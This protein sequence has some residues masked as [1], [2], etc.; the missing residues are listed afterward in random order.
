[1]LSATTLVV[2]GI[3]KNVFVPTLQLE[4]A[5][6][7]CICRK[8]SS[9]GLAILEKN[10]SYGQIGAVRF[11]WKTFPLFEIYSNYCSPSSENNSSFLASGP[12]CVTDILVK[13][14]Q[15]NNSPIQL[16]CNFNRV[17]QNGRWSFW[18]ISNCQKG[19]RKTDC[20]IT[21]CEARWWFAIILKSGRREHVD[22]FDWCPTNF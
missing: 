17:V 14:D 6:V 16:V 13:I 8:V 7:W 4:S 1:M 21:R 22:Y 19:N 10:L 20:K 5:I 15:S 11:V 18:R 3:K 12:F 2:F 9:D